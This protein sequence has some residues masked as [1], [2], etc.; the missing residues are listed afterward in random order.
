MKNKELEARI[1]ANMHEISA[2]RRELNGGKRIRRKPREEDR[3]RKYVGFADLDFIMR[4][5]ALGYNQSALAREL[6]ISQPAVRKRILR[7]QREQRESA[8]HL[9]AALH[10]IFNERQL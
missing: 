5:E 1:R 10:W 6:G 4:F 9:I 7:I 8:P 3:R 2:F